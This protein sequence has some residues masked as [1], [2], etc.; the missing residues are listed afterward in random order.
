MVS[1]A[2]CSPFAKLISR[3]MPWAFLARL[4]ASWNLWFS[5]FTI[6]I[7]STSSPSSFR[8]P[9]LLNRETAASAVCRASFV[10][11]PERYAPER[12]WSPCALPLE[13]PAF[14]NLSNAAFAMRTAS[15][16][17]S[18]AVRILD[19][20]R[21][22][23]ASILLSPMLPNPSEASWPALNA[24]SSFSSVRCTSAS[25]S[26]IAASPRLSSALRK[27][28][29]SS[30]AIRFA[31]FV[32]PFT[33]CA[34]MMMRKESATP[35]ESFLSRKVLR[36]SDAAFRA[37]SASES[38]RWPSATETSINACF[39][40]SAWLLSSARAEYLSRTPSTGVC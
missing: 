2:R 32:S 6:A 25:E 34:R 24:S 30:S 7:L 31:S 12:T 1:R 15:G 33:Q 11:P 9:S 35:T 3:N 29:S 28:C 22:A 10:A 19:S 36:A 4:V 16:G 13:S 39:E 37:S 20:V 23:M 40:S 17:I 38:D 26:C 14:W 5:V 21:N 18:S 27:A 8:L